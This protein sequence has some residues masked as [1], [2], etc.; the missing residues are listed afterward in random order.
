MIDQKPPFHGEAKVWETLEA[1]LPNNIVVYNNREISGREFDYCLFMENIGALIIEVKGWKYNEIS[2]QG[3]DNII[4]E[5]YE[6]PQRSPKKQARA[7]RFALLNKI[8]E[9]YN[10]SP[11]VFDMVCYPFITKAEY[12]TARL[13]IVSEEEFTIFKEDL[14][15]QESLIKKIQSAYDSSKNVPHADFSSEL[16]FKL[17]HDWEPDFAQCVQST[18]II[19]K[20]YS[21]L[22]VY[23]VDLQKTDIDQILTDYFNGIKR[24]IFIGSGSDYIAL[25]EAFNN[26]FK[27]H[28]IQPGRN[29]LCIGYK[30]GLDVGQC[31]SRTFNLEIYL[32][33]GLEGFAS[34]TISIEEGHFNP[35]NTALIDRLSEKTGFN[36]Q[37]YKVEHASTEHNTLVEAGAGTGKTFSM[38]S[39]VA[40]LCNKKVGAVSNIADEVAMVTFTNDAANNMK[41]RLKQMFVNYFVLTSDAR[42]LKFVEDIDRAHISTIHSFTVDILRKEV[43]YT[44]L[45]TN[46]RIS[47][48]EY[49]RGKIYDIYLSD[50][51]ADMETKNPNFIN[52]IPVPIYDLKKKIMS[53]ADRL[54]AKSIDLRQ[55]KLSEMGVTVDNTVPY[56]NELIEKVIIP[57]EEKYSEDSH[58]SNDM[59]LKE[60]IILLDKVLQQLPGKLQWIQLK[61]LFVDE[62]QDTDDVQIQAFQ[63]LQRVINADCRMFVV[64]DLKQSIYRF[65]GARLSAFTQLM[66][67]SLFDWDTYHLTINYRTDYRLLDRFDSV[68]KRMGAQNYLPYKA[69]G[70]R[71]LSSVHTDATDEDLFVS[72]PCHAKNEEKFMNTFMEVLKKQKAMILSIMKNR[73]ENHQEPLSKEERTIAI[74]VRSN[75]QV[76]KLV[77]A[78]KKKGIKID[79]K[80]GGN[81]YQLEST[82]DLYKLV[83]ALNNAANPVHMINFIESNYTG[84]ILDY[85]K[86]HG[87]TANDCIADLSRILD[88]FFT[89]RMQKTWQQIVNEAY[90]Q[91]ILYVLKHLYDALQPWKNYSHHLLDQKYYMANYEYLMERIIKYSRADTITLNQIIEHL[92]TCILT[93]QQQ[94]SRDIEF[95]DDEIQLICT[96]VHKSKGLEYGTVILPY[97]DMDIS[98]I[99]KVKLDANYSGSKLAYTVLFENNV[100][101]HNSN[102][103]E[104][105]EVDEQISEESRILYVA[106]TRAIRNCVWINNIDS[107]STI[108]WGSLMEE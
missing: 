20:P 53:V 104:S 63:K 33:E 44:G 103:N 65:R 99:G 41:A 43:L 72:I 77:S 98:D 70:D 42:Y 79:T 107:N 74:L 21:I 18:D 12:L 35:D 28:N 10:T 66:N 100:R 4:I 62:F 93:G 78:A 60:C 9:K 39:R 26:C 84:L 40:F 83:L 75:W 37:Q 32:V 101:E 89:A 76:D 68:F 81:L 17:R 52:E 80:S 45:G 49:L 55:I 88:E 38:V 34:S 108:S 22:S 29:K 57:A 96:T 56:F 50:F 105:A 13:D 25:T 67:A 73:A 27:K 47:S 54:L 94:L 1:Y 8:V 6:K 87:M 58:L 82:L 30:N 71:L 85:Q 24:I 48:N 11:L 91:P 59:D 36:L 7:Y 16:L 23:P 2:V 15:N 102:Y 61:Y 5:G 31:V 90:T 46:F 3:V 106:L 64:G 69:D 97:T 86:Y 95:D 19:T 14:E 51:L 92:K